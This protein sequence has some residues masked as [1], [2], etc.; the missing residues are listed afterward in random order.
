MP[1]HAQAA[2]QGYHIYR[3]KLRASMTKECTANLCIA[4]PLCADG[5]GLGCSSLIC[6]KPAAQASQAHLPN[7]YFPRTQ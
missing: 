2:R 7:A 6:G 1:A 3:Q 5:F 4:K